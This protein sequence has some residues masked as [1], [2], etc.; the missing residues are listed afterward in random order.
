MTIDG[1]TEK[2]RSTD[3]IVDLILRSVFHLDGAVLTPVLIEGPN[4]KAWRL[5]FLLL[6]PSALPGLAPSLSLYV[7]L[8]VSLPRRHIFLFDLAVI[9]CKRRGDNYELKDVLYLNF[10]KITNNP[11]SDREG[12]KVSG[13]RQTQNQS[14][15][16]Y[17]SCSQ[18]L[19]AALSCVSFL[20]P[21]HVDTVP[22]SYAVKQLH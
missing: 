3:R 8:Y 17:P 5:S 22:S 7:S 15:S 19:D 20:F 18:C 4:T 1:N 6:I 12:K 2:A 13:K 14:I 16:N 10:Y 21:L 9:V 11:T